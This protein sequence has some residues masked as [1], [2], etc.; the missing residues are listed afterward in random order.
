MYDQVVQWQRAG[1][2]LSEHFLICYC[3][4]TVN[5]TLIVVLINCVLSISNKEY[6]D[7]DDDHMTQPDIYLHLTLTTIYV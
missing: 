7:D 4:Q 5:L 3:T 1:L 2:C 6:D